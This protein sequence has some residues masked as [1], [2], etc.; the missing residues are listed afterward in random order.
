M[1]DQYFL[2]KK[3]INPITDTSEYRRMLDLLFEARTKFDLPASAI[4]TSLGDALMAWKAK[5]FSMKHQP[6]NSIGR[7]ICG[8]E[9]EPL[10][11]DIMTVIMRRD[12][13]IAWESGGYPRS[14][15]K[16]AFW[17]LDIADL[18]ITP[19]LMQERLDYHLMHK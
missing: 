8:W 16:M 15:V 18:V 2:W 9:A 14:V 5:R 17:D 11:D 6:S 7:D 1:E 12:R 4:P 19:E 10:C 3:I 13:R